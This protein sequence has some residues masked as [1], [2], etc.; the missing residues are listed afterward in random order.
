MA[1]TKSALK[2][3]KQSKKANLKNRSCRGAFNSI[4]KKLRAAVSTSDQAQAS[5]L[6]SLCFQRL[7]KNGKA[8]V[9]HKNKVDRKKAQLKKLVV[10][11]AAAPQA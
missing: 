9:F 3:L 7:D 8:G 11:L 6:L 1:H 10:S 4:E 2:R 5:E